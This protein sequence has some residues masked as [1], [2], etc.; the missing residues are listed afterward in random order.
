MDLS[1]LLLAWRAL[2]VE[3]APDEFYWGCGPAFW[4]AEGLFARGFNYNQICRA[5]YELEFLELE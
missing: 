1:D 4:V 2:Y 3:A 5:V